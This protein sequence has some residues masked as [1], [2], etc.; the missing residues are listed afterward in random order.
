[1]L[2]VSAS[3][4][5][6]HFLLRSNSASSQTNSL[7]AAIGADLSYAS[8]TLPRLTDLLPYFTRMSSGL[9]RLM[10]IGVIG[11]E[12]PV[13]STTWIA[14]AEMPLTFGFRY[15]GAYG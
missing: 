15:C 10:P 9:G 6:F 1:M 4:S 2:V 14:F 11:P 13:S 5:V 3:H 12:S 8:T 7:R